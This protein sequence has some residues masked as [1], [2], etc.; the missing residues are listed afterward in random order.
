MTGR[1]TKTPT[2]SSRG[3]APATGALVG[4]FDTLAAQHDQVAAM[5]GKIQDQP[6]SRAV[7]WPARRRVLVAHEH[8]E[9]RELYPVLRQFEETRALADHHDQEA[10][11]LDALIGRLD[12]VDVQSDAWTTLFKQ[13]VETVLHHAKDEEEAKIFPI[14]QRVLGEVRAVELDAKV[15]L[16][17]QKLVESH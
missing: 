3:K 16:A 12:T 7:V 13:L 17:Q 8:G 14:A 6:L 9:V 2:K 10:L 11:E 15:L 4:V 5:F 1:M